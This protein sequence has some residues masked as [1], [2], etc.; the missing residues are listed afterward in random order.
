MTLTDIDIARQAC[1]QPI[2]E[3]A[4]KLDLPDESL[5]LFGK[6]KAKVS[7]DYLSSLEQRGKLILVT[8]VFS[9]ARRRGQDDDQRGIGRRVERFGKACCGLFARAFAGTL[10]RSEGR[11]CGWGL[12]SGCTDGGAQ[13]AFHGRLPCDRYG[14]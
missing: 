1:P 13:L 8:A 5:E 14:A 4:R 6:T 3:I 12:C 9:D 7:N 2:D 10:F 11:C